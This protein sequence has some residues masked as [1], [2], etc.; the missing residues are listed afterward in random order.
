MITPD[1]TTTITD[2]VN[3]YDPGSLNSNHW[4]G[5]AR[6]ASSSATG[7]VD[8]NTKVFNTNNLVRP[9]IAQT[10][11]HLADQRLC[12]SFSTRR[13]SPHFPSVTRTVC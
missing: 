10:S 13:S 5:S 6:I 11:S 2:Y 4:V 9:I 8:E 12:S 7:V 3:N 1:N